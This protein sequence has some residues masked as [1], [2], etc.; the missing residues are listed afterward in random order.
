MRTSYATKEQ[1]SEKSSAAATQGREALKKA[2]SDL[3]IKV[4]RLYVPLWLA[5][6]MH[7]EVAPISVASSSSATETVADPKI[8]PDFVEE[9]VQTLD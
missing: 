6:D 2:R 9:W 3:E 1:E 5:G 8:L 4:V 7:T